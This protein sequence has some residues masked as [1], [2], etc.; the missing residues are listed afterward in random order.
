MVFTAPGSHFYFPWIDLFARK[1]NITIGE[2]KEARE[3]GQEL[4][5]LQAE[6]GPDS[7]AH[8]RAVFFF[9][10]KHDFPCGDAKV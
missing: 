6:T 9:G 1:V 2:K 10:K 4:Q 7:G 5:V 8:W 3:Q